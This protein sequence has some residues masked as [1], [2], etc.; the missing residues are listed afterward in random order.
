MLSYEEQAKAAASF[1]PPRTYYLEYI[2]IAF[3]VVYAVNFFVGKR[4][5]ERLA[6]HWL[7][8]IKPLFELNFSHLGVTDKPDGALM[9]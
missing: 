8:A 5:N 9:Q 4:I 6:I 3:L 7:S 1:Q 2:C